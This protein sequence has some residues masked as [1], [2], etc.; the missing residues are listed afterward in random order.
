VGVPRAA[1]RD[2]LKTG[3]ILDQRQ[4][5]AGERYQQTVAP[6]L[7]RLTA[8]ATSVQI[9]DSAR[10]LHDAA[11][12]LLDSAGRL[13]DSAQDGKRDFGRAERAFSKALQA[14]QDASARLGHCGRLRTPARRCTA[15]SARRGDR[16]LD[17]IIGCRN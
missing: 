14:F 16:A 7:Q 15:S 5:E 12:R 9:G 6:P 3:G 4:F 17:T 13:A 11:G 2:F 8:A 1:L 10:Q